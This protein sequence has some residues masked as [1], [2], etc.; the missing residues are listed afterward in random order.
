MRLISAFL[1]ER[2]QELE[3][4]IPCRDQLRQNRDQLRRLREDL[5]EAMLRE[6]LREFGPCSWPRHSS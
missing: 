2:G 5:R 6:M 1:N 3:R 4:C